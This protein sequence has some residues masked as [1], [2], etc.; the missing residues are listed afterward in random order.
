MPLHKLIL[1]PFA[2]RELATMSPDDLNRFEALL[3]T[4][5]P[6]LCAWIIG[7]EPPAPVHD[8]PVL[9]AIQA[10]RDTLYAAGPHVGGG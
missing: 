5:D 6:M 8:T 10:F 3:E 9:P 4:P 2:D 7:T 1:G